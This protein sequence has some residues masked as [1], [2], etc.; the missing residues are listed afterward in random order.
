MTLKEKV[1]SLANIKKE[2]I[3]ASPQIIGHVLLAKFP[4]ATGKEKKKIAKSW[5]ELLPNVKTV[6]EIKGISGELRQPKISKI[7]G[8]SF[9]T[10]HKEHGVLYKFDASKIMFS[11][12]NH[13][14]RKR[15]LDQIKPG[16]IVIDMFAGIGYFSLGVAKHAKHVIA[17]EKN[18]L[19]FSYL[20][21]NIKLN[22]IK[23][24]TAIN[25]D[26]RELEMENIADRVLLGYFPKTKKFLPYAKR[27]SK[28]G[29]IV[30]YHN[31][32][33]KSELW[34]KP[35]KELKDLKIMSKKVVKSYAP[36][37]VHVVIDVKV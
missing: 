22:K 25:S 18:P 27:F 8:D 16:E 36:N 37:V 15:L 11:K 34:D 3:P 33:K 31:I 30:H 9:I 23:N 26:C 14:E 6:G 12:G 35:E 21:E 5:M 32:Y 1:A 10:L 24:I 7:L 2:K 17:I 19:S 20:L 13:Y 28:K 29:A 4:N